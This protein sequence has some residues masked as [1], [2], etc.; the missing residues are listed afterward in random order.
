MTED[1]PRIRVTEDGPYQVYGTPPLSRVAVV[2]TEHGEPVDWTSPEPLPTGRR[3]ALCRCGRSKTKPFCD[4]SHLEEPRF[5]GNEVAD[6]GPRSARA[7]AFV[8]EGMVITDDVSICSRAGFCR[9]RATSVWELIG[10]SADPE[11]RERLRGMISNC[12]SG[13]LEQQPSVVAPAEEPA[14]E[15]SIAV[16]RN[17]PLWV[18]GGI[19]VEAADG[20]TYEVRNR[21]TLCR[22][23]HS[24]NK[25]FCDGSHNDVGFRDG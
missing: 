7:E 3:F 18:R 19:T 15:P 20:S 5:E 16:T 17:G 11:V 24:A 9:T 6:H 14:F 8:G 25:P 4:D 23:G 10:S 21:V 13:R 22:C 12:P 1:G 2:R